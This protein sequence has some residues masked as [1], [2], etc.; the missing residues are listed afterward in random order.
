MKGYVWTG[1]VACYD[2]R[3]REIPCRGT[4]QDGEFRLGRKWP[5][6][7]FQLADN[8][9]ID[10][11]TGL[12]WLRVANLTTGPTT[13]DEA[14]EVI[15]AL[16]RKSK[17]AKWRLP[18]IN[19]LET[20]VDCSAHNPALPAGHPFENVQEAYWSSTTSMF[21]S[22]WAWALYLLK[23]AVGVGRKDGAH[24]SVWAVGDIRE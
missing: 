12:S 17:G 5:S 2:A 20:L 10:W 23:G 3:G 1:Q 8:V 19:E 16:N 18:N 9:V 21:E 6:P 7:R 15:E 11:L 4:G 22:D 14:F 13:W 24:F